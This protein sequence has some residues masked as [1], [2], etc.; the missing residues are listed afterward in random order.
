MFDEQFHLLQLL[1]AE[2]FCVVSLFF[3]VQKLLR[4]YFYETY[5]GSVA[6]SSDDLFRGIK[7]HSLCEKKIPPG[8][9]KISLITDIVNEKIGEEEHPP[10]KL[11]PTGI[12]ETP[13]NA[14]SLI[15]F[16][17]PNCAVIP[18]A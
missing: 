16:V 3:F 14:F 7:G 11:D 8:E 4:L 10:T 18:H 9:A 13:C 6:F 12:N 2:L 5:L 15:Y 17:I 1:A